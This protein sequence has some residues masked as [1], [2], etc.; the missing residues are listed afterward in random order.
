[1]NKYNETFGVDISTDVLDC[2][3][4]KS[5]HVQNKNDE[6]GFKKLLK[7]VPTKYTQTLA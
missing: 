4:S 7:L 1:M 3:G 6:T 2:F 5:G